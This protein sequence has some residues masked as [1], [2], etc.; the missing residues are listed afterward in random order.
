M[1]FDFDDV[2]IQPATLT[3][4]D[5][6][7]VDITPYVGNGFLPLFTAPMDTVISSDNSKQFIQ[8]R[9]NV[10]Y[11]RTEKYKKY[12]DGFNSFSYEEFLFEISL[13]SEHDGV[14]KVLI[15]VA[16]GHMEKII[17]AAKLA[18]KKNP[19]I[20]IMAGNIASPHTYRLYCMSNA[21]DYV[22]LG[23]GNGNG[24]L[25]T[26]QTGIGY[27]M[28]SLI[29]ECYEIKKYYRNATKI[30][31]DGGMKKYSDIIKALAL[32]ADYVMVGSIFNKA[33]ES[34]ADTHWK[35][36]KLSPSIAK[37]MYDKGY[38]LHKEF[39]GMS[40]K[41]SQLVMG[42]TTLRTSEGVVKKQIVEYTLQQ[43]IENFESYLRSAMSYTD[44]RSL[45]DFIGKVN[46]NL[47]T[48]NSF[49]RYNK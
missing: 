24:C 43:W 34:A 3:H 15:D 45:L 29:S 18:K 30:V 31:A 26:Q 10:V 20:I 39:R 46:N 21:I 25:T 38:T 14:W 22:R 37:F 16:N 48:E 27:P 13:M 41:K 28:G 42:N 17:S 36:F 5:S 47:I 23:I 1:K 12:D 8:N 2:L 4:I 32:G 19:N 9:V 35:F 11:P 6:R 7:Y 33:L 44:C 40:S 49:N